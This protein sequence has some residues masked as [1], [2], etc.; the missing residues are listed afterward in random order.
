MQKTVIITAGGSGKRMGN[1]IPKQFLLLNNKPILQYSIEAFYNYDPTIQIILTLPKEWIPFWKDLSLKNQFLLNYEIVEGGKE[2]FYSIKNALKISKGEL[3]A[4]HDG[5]RPLVSLKIIENTFQQ[6]FELGSSIPV[7]QLTDSIRKLN[8]T[9]LSNKS[10]SVLRKD[11]V[12]VQTPQ[13]FK[14]NI[15]KHAYDQDFHE[16]ITDDASLVEQLGHKIFMTEGEIYN[17]KITTPLDLKIASFFL[18]S[19]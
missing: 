16:G 9:S 6:A 13:T 17:I 8:S 10:K 14:S 7:I 1:D 5:V 11:F 3:I 4:I 19:I 18:D 12:L 15:I 2:R